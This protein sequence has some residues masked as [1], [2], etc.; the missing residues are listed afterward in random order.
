MGGRG[1]ESLRP[2]GG[3]LSRSKWTT[4]KEKNHVDVKGQLDMSRGQPCHFYEPEVIQ[5]VSGN[6]AD[7][8][9]SDLVKLRR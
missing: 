2:E 9:T 7:P 8:A 5:F 6:I 4:R 1:R 3:T